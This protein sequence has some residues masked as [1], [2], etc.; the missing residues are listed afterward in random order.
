MISWSKKSGR[1]KLTGVRCPFYMFV[2]C[3]CIVLHCPVCS[4]K[5]K[6]RLQVIVERHDVIFEWR[7]CRRGHS[8]WFHVVVDALIPE[9]RN[10]IITIIG[11]CCFFI[12]LFSCICTIWI[13]I[14]LQFK[15]VGNFN[16]K[17]WK[18]YFD[19]IGNPNLIVSL[20]KWFHGQFD[21]DGRH[22]DGCHHRFTDVWHLQ[23]YNFW[24]ARIASNHFTCIQ[25]SSVNG[26]WSKWLK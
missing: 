14:W 20:L 21:G 1:N 6:I 25:C 3:F 2:K 7:R 10:V 26:L 13:Q 12:L 17:R 18:F 8:L 15:F 4:R 19:E 24:S 22:T 5:K 16:E 11:I 23:T 9:K